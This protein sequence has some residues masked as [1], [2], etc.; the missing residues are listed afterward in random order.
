MISNSGIQLICKIPAAEMSQTLLTNKKQEKVDWIHATD[1]L[2]KTWFALTGKN[3]F[4]S[5]LQGGTS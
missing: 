4:T 5:L 1:I 2:N 3:T